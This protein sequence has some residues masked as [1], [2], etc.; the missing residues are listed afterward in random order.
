MNTRFEDLFEIHILMRG[1][2]YYE[3]GHVISLEHK[4]LEYHGIVAGTIDYNVSILLNNYRAINRM[5]CT[6]PYAGGNNCKH[7]AAVLFAINNNEGYSLNEL[8]NDEDSNEDI[9]NQ[10]DASDLKSLLPNFAEKASPVSVSVRAVEDVKR[11]E[12]VKIMN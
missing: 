1:L 6:C 5:T 3:S 2:D 12:F 10:I 8:E 4:N 9:V 11:Q 7:M